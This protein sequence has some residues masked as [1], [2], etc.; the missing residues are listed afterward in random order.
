V[1]VL[2]VSEVIKLSW[3]HIRW[4]DWLRKKD[5]MGVAEIKSG[6]G[7]KDRVVNI[8]KKLMQDLYDYADK[9]GK[10]NRISYSNRGNDI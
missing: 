9:L 8:P 5:G 2:R 7:M 1:Q 10:L 3:N 4:I 6:K